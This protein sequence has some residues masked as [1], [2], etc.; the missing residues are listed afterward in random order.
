MIVG[1]KCGDSQYQYSGMAY[2]LDSYLL[3]SKVIEE[4][5]KLGKVDSRRSQVFPH[6]AEHHEANS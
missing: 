4:R 3:Y 2:T 6:Y 5:E 1:T